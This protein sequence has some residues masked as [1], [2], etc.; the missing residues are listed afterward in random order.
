MTTEG[1]TISVALPPPAHWAMY[2]YISVF[3]LKKHL[4]KFIQ[5]SLNFKVLVLVD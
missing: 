3:Y 1:G 5:K 2:S 4:H